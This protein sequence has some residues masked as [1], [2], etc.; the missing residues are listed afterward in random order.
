MARRQEM[1][2]FPTRFSL[3]MIMAIVTIGCVLF[4]AL[5]Y[6]MRTQ[7]QFVL[8]ESYVMDVSDSSAIVKHVR[9]RMDRLPSHT[10]A[11][12]GGEG[13]ADKLNYV[14]KL[15]DGSLTYVVLDI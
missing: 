9:A 3:R 8:A 13:G 10:L 4:S 15:S 2:C 1:I 6:Q 5:S 12:S 14:V 7:C 11:R